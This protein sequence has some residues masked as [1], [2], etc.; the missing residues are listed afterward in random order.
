[1][2]DIR[3]ET[4]KTEHPHLLFRVHDASDKAAEILYRVNFSELELPEP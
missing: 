4:T 1:M 2:L 3:W